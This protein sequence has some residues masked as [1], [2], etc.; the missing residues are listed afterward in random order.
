MIGRLQQGDY[1]KFLKRVI[2]RGAIY[3]GLPIGIGWAFLVSSLIWLL[4]S[5]SYE[6]TS[7]FLFL[8]RYAVILFPLSGML[9]E[10]TLPILKGRSTQ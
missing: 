3:W 4:G 5:P 7:I 6:F 1:M 8:A 9:M 10:L 2:I